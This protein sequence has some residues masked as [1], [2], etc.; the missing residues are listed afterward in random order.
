MLS[1]RKPTAQT[2][3]RFLDA[4][5]TLP[6][7]YKEVGATAG[8]PPADYALDHVRIKLGEGEAIFDRAKAALQ[9]WEQFRLGWVEPCLPDAPLK[10][11][12]VVAILG[13]AVGAWWLNACRIV[14]VVDE[15]KP[16]TRFGFAYGTLPAHVEK[17]EERFMIEWNHED[18]SIW[19]DILAFSKPNHVLTRFGYP[20]VRRAQKQFGRDATRSMLRAIGD[21]GSAAT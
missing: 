19:F 13:R 17:G 21:L 11:G 8:S 18:D 1:L 3:R 7:S 4:Q 5:A 16:F 20:L 12:Q 10:T 15:Q 14:Y 6:F 9:R 2:I